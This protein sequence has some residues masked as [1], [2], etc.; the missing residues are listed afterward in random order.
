[1]RIISI[2]VYSK[3]NNNEPILLASADEL[4]FVSIFQRGTLREFIKFHSRLVVQRT[5]VDQSLEVALEKGICYSTV[6]SDK[7]AVA[8]ICDE[9]YPRRVANDLGFKI[10]EQL[11]NHIYTNNINVSSF[12]TDTDI[13]FSYLDTVIKEWQNPHEKDGILKLQGELNDVTNSMKKNL[14]ELLERNENLEKLMDK[15]KALST[16]SV[17]FYKTAKKTNSCC[18]F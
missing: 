18:N 8:I 1:M 4:S 9:E 3:Q 16:T 6:N 14:N 7:L 10:M 2:S 12:T 17:Q 15:S 13:K 11:T 5:A